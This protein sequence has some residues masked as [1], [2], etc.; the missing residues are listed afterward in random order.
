MQTKATPQADLQEATHK[1]SGPSEDAELEA[2]GFQV[3]GPWLPRNFVSGQVVK[4]RKRTTS[5][6]KRT[7]GLP[8]SWAGDTQRRAGMTFWASKWMAT[9]QGSE[10]GPSREEEMN[11]PENTARGHVEAD[12]K[13]SISAAQ[14][15]G[16]NFDVRSRAR[17]G[18]RLHPRRAQASSH[19][20]TPLGPRAREEVRVLLLEAGFG[21]VGRPLLSTWEPAWPLRG[22]WQSCGSR[23]PRGHPHFLAEDIIVESRLRLALLAL[24]VGETAPPAELAFAPS[25]RAPG[26]ACAAQGKHGLGRRRRPWL[27]GRPALSRGPGVTGALFCSEATLSTS[28]QPRAGPH[29]RPV[30]RPCLFYQPPPPSNGHQNGHRGG[31]SLPETVARGN[32]ELWPRRKR[33][34]GRKSAGLFWI[35]GAG[36]NRAE[37]VAKWGAWPRRVAKSQV[38]VSEVGGRPVPPSTPLP[39]ALWLRR[40]YFTRTSPHLGLDLEFGVSHTARPGDPRVS[41]SPRSGR[42]SQRWNRDPGAALLAAPGRA[43]GLCLCGLPGPRPPQLA[44]SGAG[45]SW[46]RRG[47]E[48]RS[49]RRDSERLRGFHRLPSNRDALGRYF[50]SAGGPAGPGWR[51]RSLGEKGANGQG[52]GRPKSI[53]PAPVAPVRRLVSFE[54]LPLGNRVILNREARR[55]RNVLRISIQPG[56]APL[57]GTPKLLRAEKGR[58]AG[59]FGCGKA[60]PRLYRSLCAPSFLL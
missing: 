52:S 16:L 44:A 37:E 25:G 17:A 1:E 26:L 38:P 36:V 29:P 33:N 28:F 47:R 18:K 32:G 40:G 13:L 51:G 59:P 34:A 3:E 15:K 5:T 48:Q 46:P 11:H 23:A 22:C 31:V 4:T 41:S 49:L 60:E 2:K 56:P 39:P 7:L 24:V 27:P 21:E 55:D 54:F 6:P 50:S 42:R 10:E 58:L 9:L 19:S 57:R 53:R 30:R 43:I 8:L 14:G 20:P 45:G 35:S 12:G